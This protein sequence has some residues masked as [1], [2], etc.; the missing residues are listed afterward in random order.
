[1]NYSDREVIRCLSPSPLPFALPHPFLPFT[2][3]E[4]SIYSYCI[5]TRPFPLILASFP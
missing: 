2:P 1:M 4:F 5:T 3:S